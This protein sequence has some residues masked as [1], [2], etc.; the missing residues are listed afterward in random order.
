[1]SA[2]AIDVPG[3]AE[4]LRA[5]VGPEHVLTDPSQIAPFGHDESGLADLLPDLVVLPRTTE[6]VSSVLRLCS[7]RRVPVTP[8]AGRS[9]K[10][11]G[12]LPLH[13]GLSLSLSRMD[14][15]LAV[16]KEDLVG[17]VQPGVVTADYMR[18]VEALGLFYPPDPS[19]LAWG[20][21]GGNVAENAGGPRA[22]Q[23]GVTRDYI[24]GLEV[25]LASGE[26]LRCGKQTIKGVAGYDLVGLIVGS[27]GTLAVI[28]E[29]T[30]KLL[31]LPRAVETALCLFRDDTSASR[32][33]SAVLAAGILPR[34]MEFLDGTA[35]AA[36]RVAK[37]PYRFPDACAAAVLC[38]VDGDRSE[39][40]TEELGRL[41]QICFA[42]GA[43]DILYAANEAQRRD[44]WETRRRVSV[45]LKALHPRKLSEDVVVPRSKIPEMVARVGEIGRRLG[46]AVACYGHAGDGNLHA[47]VLY[48]EEA[49]RPLV[50]RAVAEMLQAAVALGGTITGEHG[51]GLAKR[52]FLG[53]EQG[54]G[55]IAL[56]RKLKAV[57]D[58]LGI[59]NPGKIFPPE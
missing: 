15:I 11:G 59:L 54:P 22:L 9:G 3:L 44:L 1:M 57:F 33:V 49:Q 31:P 30:T 6:E 25:V 2:P 52:D 19:S 4:A 41:G 48:D 51:V 24:L 16:R 40:C 50:E 45:D 32:A 12:S 8:S 20:T 58:P 26:V 23:Y 35:I 13:G 28:T 5:I 17:V 55:L 21:L 36:S 7:E 38:E 10:S 46:L 18:A 14:R 56:Q 37:A 29:I 43:V 42:E 34:A 39:D 47:N 27:E 53:L